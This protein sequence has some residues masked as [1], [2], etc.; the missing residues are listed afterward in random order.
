MAI[1]DIEEIKEKVKNVLSFSQDIPKAELNIDPLMEKWYSAKREIIQKFGNKLIYEAG[2]VR[3]TLTP[4]VQTSKLNDFI[5]RIERV[6]GNNPL[7]WFL[8]RNGLA[9]FSN[10]VVENYILPSGETIPKGMKLLKAFKFFEK[11]E[12]LLKTLQTE[13]SMLIQENVIEGV[14]CFSVH[15]LDYLSSSENTYNWRSCH[16]LDGEFRSG[17]LSYMCDKST[18]VCYLRGKEEEVYLPRFPD[19]V[20]WNS[21]KW[22]MLIFLSESG[23]SMFAG[24]QYPFATESSLDIIK[25]YLNEALLLSAYEWSDW[26][27]DMITYHEYT[28]GKDNDSTHRAVVINKKIYTLTDL[29]TNGENSLHFNDVLSSSCYIPYYRWRKSD[30]ILKTIGDEHFTIG[31]SAPCIAC[32]QDVICSSEAMFCDNC[33]CNYVNEDEDLIECECCGGRVWGEDAYI[34]RDGSLVCEACINEYYSACD[35]CGNWERTEELHYHHENE[36]Y[37]CYPCWNRFYSSKEVPV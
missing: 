23:Q 3:F 15:P 6:Y 36:E 18:I 19:T 30:Y 33:F 35:H 4:E 16:A 28:N 10:V 5:A 31:E 21:K 9:F 37:Y 34:T 17:N 29:V 7:A 13:A 11:D 8:Y 25:P 2:N 20:K 1:I 12:N 14:L 32:G 24:R 27:D 22:R 26:H